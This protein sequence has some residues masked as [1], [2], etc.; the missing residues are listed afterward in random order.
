MK[1]KVNRALIDQWVKEAYPNGLYKLS[2]K[3]G[4]PVNSLTKIRLGAWIPKDPNARASLA[5]E[6][7][8]QE[9]ELFPA[10]TGKRDAS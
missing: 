3:T 6:L 10:P 9:T 7:K 2:E 8:V 5:R 1:K 4:I